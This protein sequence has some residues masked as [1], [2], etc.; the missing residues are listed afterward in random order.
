MQNKHKFSIKH[1]KFVI[2]K[3]S[4]KIFIICSVGQSTQ[5]KIFFFFLAWANDKNYDILRFH[6]DKHFLRIF[7]HEYI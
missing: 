2:T 5:T 6:L 4:I 3:V 1:I 7:E